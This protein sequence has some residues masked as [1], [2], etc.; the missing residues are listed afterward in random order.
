MG[1]E[2]VKTR[3]KRFGF[4]YTFLDTGGGGAAGTFTG[5][6]RYFI[7]YPMMLHSSLL[8]TST[9]LSTNYYCIAVFQQS[10]SII[11]SNSKASDITD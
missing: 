7:L 4:S 8:C 1:M 9:S 11:W 10:L 5:A 3:V 2:I 6:Y